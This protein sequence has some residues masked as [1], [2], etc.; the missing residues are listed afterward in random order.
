M[1]QDA[2]QK[3]AN[4]QAKQ[5]QKEKSTP[6]KL[7]IKV[8]HE[9]PGAKKVKEDFVPHVARPLTEEDKKLI[10]SMTRAIEKVSKEDLEY[11]ENEI[12]DDD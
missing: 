1:Q 4:D 5:A 9:V 2:E 12:R 11:I 7:E 3:A 10:E 6:Q 8:K